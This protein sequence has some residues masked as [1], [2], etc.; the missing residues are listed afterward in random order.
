MTSPSDHRAAVEILADGTV[1]V[2]GELDAFSARAVDAAL[3]AL[4]AGATGA[5]DGSG[6]TF[7][8]SS[9]LRVL[10]RHRDRLVASGGGLRFCAASEP[11][12]RLL[13]LTRLDALL[14][15][16][17]STREGGTR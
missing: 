13:D 9:V 2:S 5:V 14:G 15:P 4:P 11:V 12:R 8:D 3:A 1:A 6:A 17:P 16:P 7:V 10:L